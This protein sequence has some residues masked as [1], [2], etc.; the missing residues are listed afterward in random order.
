MD[1]RT[2]MD[3]I[4]IGPENFVGPARTRTEKIL[5]I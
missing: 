4:E 5:V 3:R 1:E 2:K